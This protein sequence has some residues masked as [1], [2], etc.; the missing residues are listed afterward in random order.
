MIKNS[1]RVVNCEAC[2]I[3]SILREH[4]ARQKNIIAELKAE[5]KQI[6]WD[7]KFGLVLIKN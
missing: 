6:E 5:L 2:E 4:N 7:K 1:K 3:V